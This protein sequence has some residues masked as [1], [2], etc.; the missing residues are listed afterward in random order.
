MSVGNLPPSKKVT[1][2][3]TYVTE[4]EFNDGLVFFTSP[5]PIKNTKAN[6]NALPYK[7]SMA[8]QE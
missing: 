7:A 5:T 3:I 8:P 4:L 2:T 6:N 1:I